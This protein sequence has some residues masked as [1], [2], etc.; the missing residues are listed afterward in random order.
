MSVY[1]NDNAHWLFLSV[2][3]M[4]NQTLK[5]DE[6]VIVKDGPLTNELD[7]IINKFCTDYAN[8]F[9]IIA[10]PQNVGL[11]LALRS[12]ILEC[13]NELIAR[14]DS[15]DISAPN[16]CERQINYMIS[17]PD[18]GM[19]GCVIDEFIGE[20]TNTT[21]R[22]M[23]PENHDEIIKF[24]KRRVPITHPTVIFKKSDVINC[25][26]YRKRHLVEDYDI[27][28]RLLKIG[29]KAHN[30][31][32]PLLYVRVSEDFYKRRGGIKYLK[33]LL[34]FNLELYKTGWASKFDFVVR[35]FANIVVCVMPNIIR[36]FIY[37][38]LLRKQVV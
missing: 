19:V 24:S 12:G 9:K 31:Q 5:P 29:V 17:H 10:L 15:D 26:N 27:I 23:L 14:M 4:L 22:R 34:D 16:R 25:G 18:I 6:I 8:L 30:I 11:G 1:K 32:T 20:I 35:S 21:A 37:K 33:S 13:K 3:S 7:K 38:K 36:D 28:V 2:E